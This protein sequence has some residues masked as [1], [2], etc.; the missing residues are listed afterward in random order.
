MISPLDGPR[1]SAPPRFRST[2]PWVSSSGEEAVEL[3]A[4][5]GLDLDPWQQLVLQ[6]SLGE[7]PDGKWAAFEVGL[8]VARQNG[9]GAILEAR[10]LAGLFLLGE[11]M[12]I[13]SAHEFATSLEAFVRILG[14]IE[15]TPDLSRRL[16]RVSKSHGDEGIELLSGQRLRFRTRTKGGGRGFSCDCLVLDEAMVL[17]RAM[18]GAL[19]PT[20]AARMDVTRSGPQ[21]WY[22]GSAVD[23]TVHEHGQVLAKIRERGIDGTDP[24]LS[25][26]EWSIDV[27]ALKKRGGTDRGLWA[28]ANP[29]F[30]IRLDAELVATEQRSM[31]GR[32]FGTERLSVGYWPRTDDDADRVISRDDWD[33]CGDPASTFD[34]PATF[35]LDI[36][37]LRDRAAIAVA[38]RRADGAP[39]VEIVEA[40][41]GVGWIVGRLA[42]LCAGNRDARVAVDDR[43]PAASLI[44]DLAAAGVTV[45]EMSTRQYVESCAAFYDDAINRRLRY[46]S[47]QPELDSALTAAAVRPLGDSWAWARRSAADI[48]PLVAATLARWA[49]LSAKPRVRRRV[50]SLSAALAREAEREREKA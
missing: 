1:G 17:P 38:G 8:V 27:E 7:R 16:K 31:D 36:T 25:Y 42:D 30:G 41:S 24:R 19:L 3:A 40:E 34:G 15:D 13:H 48:S 2:P 44:G 26:F 47:P 39:H 50:V 33:A 14:L 4:L 20:L 18:H 37:P 6:E 23:E 32:T 28:E 21:V 46:P 43:S 9:K 11:R 22:T 10:E 5:A 12:I 49:A 45:V 35:G 29:G